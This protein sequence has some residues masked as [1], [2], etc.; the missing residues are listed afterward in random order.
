MCQFIETDC[1]IRIPV[2]LYG[3]FGTYTLF[4]KGEDLPFEEARVVVRSLNLKSSKE[5]NKLS[6][7]GKRP[8]GIPSNPHII[9]K[10]EWISWYDFLGTTGPV[11]HRGDFFWTYPQARKVAN[12]LKLMG[13]TAFRAY[14]KS[15]ERPERMP[16]DPHK[17]Y[18]TRGTWI[19]WYDFL[20]KKRKGKWMGNKYY[21]LLKDGKYQFAYR[22]KKVS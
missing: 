11:A 2:Y 10:E 3:K 8:H 17:F 19:D 1:G 9:Y 22:T 18:K 21:S 13:E 5:W 15:D 7:A 16:F 20:G 14:A 4:P 6:K 12:K